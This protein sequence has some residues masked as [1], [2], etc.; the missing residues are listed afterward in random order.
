MRGN[1]GRRCAQLVMVSVLILAG[2]S[3]LRAE[4]PAILIGRDD[5][6]R[7]SA[8]GPTPPGDWNR[9]SFDDSAWSAGRAGF[10]YGEPGARTILGA[11]RGRHTAV[12][13]RRTFE[14]ERVD[15][16]GSL[17]L[18]MDYDDGFVA[19]LNGTP[20]ASA[21]LTRDDAGIRVEPHEAEGHETFAI[22][23]VRA[24]LRPGKNVLAIEGHNVAAESSDFLLDPM[25]ATRDVGAL[26]AA[27]YVADVDELERRL[28]DQSSYLT[29][30]GFDH[31][32]A[33]TGLRRSAGATTPD[34]FA[35]DVHKLVMQIGDCHASVWPQYR[36]PTPGHL[37]LRLG[38]VEG[39][40][41]A[42]EVDEDRPL[43]P[44]CPYIE[45]I[46]GVPLDRWLEAAA[47]YV[48]R[49][50]PQLVRRRSFEGLA[51]VGLLRRE[52]GLPAAGAATIGLRSPDGLRHAERRLPL[53][54]RAADVARV[55]E[56]PSRLLDGNIGYLRIAAMD[57]RLVEPAAAAIR[58]FRNTRGLIIDVRDNSGGTYGVLRG[59]YGFFVPDDAGPR[60]TNIAAYRL[61][62]E[63]ARDHIEYRP[64][65]RAD[66][67][68]WDDR[69]RAAIRRAAATFR[70]E[71]TPPAGQFSEWHYMILGRERSGRG[72]PDR[73]HFYYDRPVVVLC[74]AGSFSATDGFLNAF[75]DLPRAT[76]VG[77]PSGGGSGSARQFLLPRTRLLVALS[78][79]ASY[80]PDGRLFDGN[81]VEV[82]VVAR[83]RLED[84]TTD[85][86]AV[87]AR[88]IA[89]IDDKSR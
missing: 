74:N 88:G 26:T 23:D 8:G 4:T 45:S 70:P 51:E 25:L 6:W 39:G 77:E 63:F 14:V 80:R 20:V 73:D 72:D 29:R 40:V 17:F 13:I 21:C 10:G 7:Y 19:Y 76:L 35:A 55:R 61:G 34:R 52:L 3:C 36:T 1:V 28:L 46:D 47:R 18:Y 86:D 44:G 42:L 22:A 53:V 78:S 68:G 66:W 67:V 58:S 32:A 59:I 82:D 60:V 12:Y 81:G 9:A 84:F 62:A 50:S 57:D 43:D 5:V 75:A 79:M 15:E 54:D 30:L 41:A 49:G 16:V 65:Y 24:L 48:P 83:P 37:P 2:A 31:R 33:L 85:A 87:L 56:R 38:D 64:T 69:E 27:D 89:A 71:W 11:M